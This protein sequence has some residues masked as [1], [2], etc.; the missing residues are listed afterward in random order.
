MR[1]ALQHLMATASYREAASMEQ[2]NDKTLNVSRR[3]N[4]AIF[5]SNQ[6]TYLAT[7]N[8]KAPAP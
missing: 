3:N 4:G 7:L 2:A 6:Q 5:I 1:V 8:P